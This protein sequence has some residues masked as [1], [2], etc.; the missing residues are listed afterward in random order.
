MEPGL[1]SGTH[2]CTFEWDTTRYPDPAGF[3]KDM[4]AK[5]VTLSTYGQHHTYSPDSKIYMEKYY[6]VTVHTPYGVV[7][8]PNLAGEKN[9]KFS[10]DKLGTGTREYSCQ[11]L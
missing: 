9:H 1:Q 5:G 6:P 3:V 4:L 7:S 8:V 10:I 2:P 11:R